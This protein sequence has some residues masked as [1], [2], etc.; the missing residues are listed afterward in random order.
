MTTLRPYAFA[1]MGLLA[2]TAVTPV[3]AQANT[4]KPSK[5]EKARMTKTERQERKTERKAEKRDAMTNNMSGNTMMHD[6]MAPSTM[7]NTAQVQANIDRANKT[8]SDMVALLDQIEAR[9]RG[10]AQ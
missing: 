5:Q 9:K 6:N 4:P 10:G 8:L 2:V 3:F 7:N 1:L